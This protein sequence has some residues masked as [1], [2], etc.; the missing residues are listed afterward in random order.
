M[1]NNDDLIQNLY[2]YF[3]KA[4]QQGAAG[5]SGSEVLAFEAMGFAPS[6]CSLTGNNVPA[7]AIE[8]ISGKA[9][10]LPKIEGGVYTHTMR[11]V[12]GTYGIMLGG[13]QPS[14]AA[15]MAAF[16]D[17]K[18]QAQEGYRTTLGSFDGPDQYHPVYALPVDWYDVTVA[19]NW[20]SY[21]YDTSA[22][23]PAPPSAAPVAPNVHVQWQV[24][25]EA[26]RPAI[27][28]RPFVLRRIAERPPMIESV[29][30]PSAFQSVARPMSTLMAGRSMR[31]DA[32]ALN[33]ATPA[34]ITM[35]VAPAPVVRPIEVAQFTSV[36]RLVAQTQ[37]QPVQTQEFK[38]S[39]DYCLV[40]LRRPWFSEDLLALPGW[41]VPNMH[42]GDYASGP[43]ANTGAFAMIPTAFIAVKN[44]VIEGQWSD[45]D[46]AAG[47]NSAGFGPFSLLVSPGDQA[48]AKTGLTAP[49]LQIIA[50]ICDAQPQLPPDPDPAFATAATPAP[51]ATTPAPPAAS[52]P[53]AG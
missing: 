42:N 13:S 46:V 33:V 1:A 26:L 15:A 31:G 51:P 44:L 17:L 41:Y 29:V 9:D 5:G 47:A 38:M 19:N 18:S 28:P 40:Q 25:P 52:A 53:G 4:Y 43:P 16:S 12:S 24:I 2:A 32:V 27:L 48:Q 10:M 37:P 14:S 30:Q 39:F 36:A 45:A 20:Q 21:S 8:E 22:Q 3:L 49:G 7:A 34:G 50:W 6:C 11:T 23:T 35:G